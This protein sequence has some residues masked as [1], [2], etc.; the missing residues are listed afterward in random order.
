[1]TDQP[2]P[3][4][5]PLS[6]EQL[7]AL[8][9][10]QKAIFLQLDNFDRQFFGENFSP[11]TLGK[12]L[13]RK[14]EVVLSRR[15]LEEHDRRVRARFA[16]GAQEPPAPGPASGKLTPS[17]LALGAGGLAGLVGVG[18]LAGKI[19]PEGKAG[20]RGVQ[21]R[22]LVEPLVKT[23]ARQQRTD[24]RFDPPDSGG[25]IHGQVLLRTSAGLLPG[26][27][28]VLTPLE[29]GTQAFVS[30]VSSQSL[31]ESIKAGGVNLLG[32]AKDALRLGRSHDP[33]NLLDLA[34]KVVEHGTEIAKAVD[35]LDLEDKAWEAIQ[36]AAEPLQSIYDEKMVLVN[37]QRL[38]LEMAWDDYRSCPRCRVE[39]GAEDRECRV[40]GTERPPKPDQPDP[41]VA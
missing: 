18:V 37:D 21:P 12:A 20:W 34:G 1:M 11:T 26:L 10:T 7:A 19:A 22:D 6:D 13:E 23:F 15:A 17:D 31:L 35:D 30:K 9:E 25:A 2:T 40:C 38:K 8:N 41:R 28:I 33:A 3:N 32:L 27:N 5:S 24:I 36:R 16:A 4:Y 29:E 14:W 39:F